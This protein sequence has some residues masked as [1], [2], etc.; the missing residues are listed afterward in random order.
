LISDFRRDLNIVYF[1]LGI[2]PASNLTP[3]VK[4][5][6]GEIP[7]RKYTKVKVHYRVHKTRLLFLSRAKRIRSMPLHP[8]SLRFVL[9]VFSHLCLRLPSGFF[10][11][12]YVTD[13]L[14][15]FWRII[16]PCSSH[17]FILQTWLF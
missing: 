14:Y 15:A 7:R 11:S 13:I 16:M 17:L 9:I 3:G 5:D 10:Y 12:F 8:V 6:A 2:S 4:F 1:L